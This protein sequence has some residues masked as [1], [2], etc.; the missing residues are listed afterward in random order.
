MSTAA[1]S[2]A[3]QTDAVDAEAVPLAATVAGGMGADGLA[4]LDI[5]LGL[6]GGDRIIV[7]GQDLSRSV[8]RCSVHVDRGSPAFPVA[9]L[10]LRQGAAGISGPGI[11]QVLPSDGDAP[12]LVAQAVADWIE[13]LDPTLIDQVLLSGGMGASPGMAALQAIANLARSAAGAR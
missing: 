9:V 7:N 8:I 4:A 13:E 5:S 1:A 10:E 3:R 12:V 6:A 11:V 2:A